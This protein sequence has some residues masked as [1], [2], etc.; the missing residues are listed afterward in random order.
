M[1]FTETWIISEADAK[2]YQLPNYKHVYNYRKTRKGGGVSIYIHDSIKYEVTEDL[3]ENGNHYL[4]VHIKKLSLNIGVIYKPGDSNN[5]DFLT[6]YS[7]QLE[8][9]RRAIVFGDFNMDLLNADNHVTKYLNEI[10]G[11]GY[12]ILNKINGLYSTRETSTT[13]SILDHVCTNISNHSFNFSIIES[14]LSDHKQIY[15]EIG[16]LKPQK[17][18]KNQYKAINYEKLYSDALTDSYINEENDYY[19]LEQFITKHVN[20]NKIDKTKILNPPQNDWINRTISDSIN[21]R[22]NLWQQTKS[23]PKDGNI[24]KTFSKQRDA[25][26]NLI[27]TH[28]KKYYYDLFYNSNNQPKKMWELINNL[29]LNKIKE[30]SAPPKLMSSSGPITEG[31][32]ICNLFNTFFSSIGQELANE[33]PIIY[34][35]NDGNTLMYEHNHSHDVTLS[36]LTPCTEDEISKIIDGLDSNTST[37]I[38]GISTKVIKCLKNIIVPKLTNCINE[39][40]MRGIFPNT[41]K[42]AKVSPIYKSG[43]RTDPGNYRP[44]SV[45]PVLSKV[46]ERVLY[47]RLNAYLLEKDFLIDEQYGFRSKSSTL[48]ATVDLVTKIKT[49]IDQKDVVLGVFIDLKKAF[50]TVCHHKL[51]QKLNN[52][53]VRDKALEMFTSYLHNRQQVVKID[54]FTSSI[55]NVPYGC[56]QG[57][58]L[59]TLLFLI[60]INNI[61]KIGLTGHLTLYADDTC[62]FYFDKSIHTNI[63]NAQKDLGILSEWLKYNLLTINTSKTTYMIFTAKNKPLPDF[64]PLTINNDTIR[65]S[66]HEKYLGLRVDDKLTWKLHIE[67]VKSKLT[68]LLASLRKISNCIPRKIRT[69]IYNSLVKSHLEYLIE[70]WGCAAKTILMPLQRTQNKIIKTLYHYHYLTP[71]KTLFEKTK[72]LNLKQLYTYGTCILIKKITTNSVQSKLQLHKKTISYNLR[73]KNKLQRRQARTNYGKKTILFEGAQ[74]FND[75]PND[76]KDCEN[77]NRFKLKLRNYVYEM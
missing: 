27:K 33:I 24:Q 67:H 73:N 54:K 15:L 45:L 34:H 14:C 51:L 29:A 41:L 70:I 56:P 11:N 66:S 31:N 2:L 32:A 18:K 30:S 57:S 71:T 13:K 44:V 77:I 52:I 3:C 23:Y 17:N 12:E 43:S 59:S 48:T 39:Y 55:K 42:V 68:S 9:R 63:T 26:K 72:L 64:P 25:V 40:M 75:L 21:L 60:Y 46:F 7:A 22:N 74:L 58:I 62:L 5:N 61:N 49:H 50:D 65:R 53:G 16:S 37:G 47:S 38:D 69:I 1:V 19:N 36:K 10:K 35:A 4:W 6:T 8:Q 20:N 28:K 76:V